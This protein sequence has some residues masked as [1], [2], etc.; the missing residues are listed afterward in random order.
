MLDEA[1]GGKQ[2]A[3]KITT[4]A[5]NLFNSHLQSKFSKVCLTLVA[6]HNSFKAHW[7]NMPVREKCLCLRL[8]NQQQ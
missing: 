8:W 5:M 7:A 2:D 3:A 6:G 1:E 4:D